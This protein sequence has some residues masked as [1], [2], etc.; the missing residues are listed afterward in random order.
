M[1]TS[2]LFIS[3]SNV[4]GVQLIPNKDYSLTTNDIIIYT[5][6]LPNFKHLNVDLAAFLNSSELNRAARFYKQIDRNRFTVYRSI[7]KFILAAHTKMEVKDIYL[8]YDL[9]KKP[10]LASQP[11][12]YFNI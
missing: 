7:L 5:V 6:Y 8:N 2:R 11:W 4:K 9:N 12:L 1:K 3:S 10:Y